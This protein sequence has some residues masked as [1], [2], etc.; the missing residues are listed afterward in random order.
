MNIILFGPQGSGKGTQSRK[1]KD[2]YKFTHIST[3]DL[4]R[5]KVAPKEK[6][7]QEEDPLTRSIKETMARG[8]LVSNDI[9]IELIQENLQENNMFDGF[10]RTLEQAKALDEITQID[11][12]IELRLSDDTAVERVSSRTQCKEC[13]AIFG[14]KNPPKEEGMCNDCPGEIYQR[15]DDKPAAIKERLKDYRT[16]TEP[17][18]EYYKPRDIVH[19]IDAS[20]EIE[21]I[22]DEICKIIETTG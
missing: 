9:V 13:A 10:P 12:V 1:L 14:P 3:G 6:D 5:E 20:K 2:K 8:G 4:I 11:L 19:S 21:E 17:L 18:L 7:S 16:E 22:F 15:E